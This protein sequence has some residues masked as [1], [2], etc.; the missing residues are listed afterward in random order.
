MMNGSYDTSKF[1]VRL[2]GLPWNTSQSEV[3]KF[4]GGCK[5]RRLQ[6]VTNDQGRSTGECFV[7]LETKED[8]NL[9]KSFDKNMLGTRYIE[10]FES[11]HDAMSDMLRKYNS[12]YNA[13]HP[14]NPENNLS[15]NDN[16]Q[17]PAVRLR[18]LPYHATKSDIS[19]F[20]DGLDIAQNGIHISSSK[21]AGEAFVAFVNMD[22]AL[23]AL[24]F[25]RMNMGHRYIEVFKSTY[26]EARASILNDTQMMVRQKTGGP[27]QRQ[28]SDTN[29]TGNNNNNNNN[30]NNDNSCNINQYSNIP[31]A[32]N[33]YNID[34]RNGNNYP[35]VHNESGP[36]KRS[37]C[38]SFTMKLRGVPF[39]ATEQDVYDFFNPIMPI[40]VEQENAV[41]IRASTWYVE[42]GSRE[43]ANEAMTYD[44]K[45]MGSRYIEL[46]PLYDDSTRSKR[47]RN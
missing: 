41:R 38:A 20:F 25:N 8:V 15:S 21:P 4:L 36:V 19:K 39:E 16:W 3:I 47:N 11:N 45:Y 43:E 30:N 7:I 34:T 2:R 14:P 18:G 13:N 35:M 31:P 6:F 9:A 33:N 23:R 28:G 40:R 22:N 29:N 5:I 1:V 27:V 10:I 37:L 26:G 17:E 32:S 44:R 42:F 46:L 24:E 12:D